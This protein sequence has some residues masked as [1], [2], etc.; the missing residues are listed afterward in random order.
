[1]A[2]KA[3]QFHEWI[4]RL[5]RVGNQHRTIVPKWV[6]SMSCGC[7]RTSDG[8]QFEIKRKTNG[9]ALCL[10][11]NQIVYRVS[12]TDKEGYQDKQVRALIKD[13]T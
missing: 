10:C 5:K 6:E 13:H 2:G 3:S 4:K 7:T 8:P 12:E 9:D 1:M 11:C